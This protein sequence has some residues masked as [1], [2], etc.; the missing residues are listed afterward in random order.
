MSKAFVYLWY[1][2]VNRKYYLGSHKGSPDDNYTHSSTIW[3]SF[4]KNNV[5]KGTKRRILAYGTLEDMRHLETKLLNN[6]KLRRWSQYYNVWISRTPPHP[7]GLQYSKIK[8]NPHLV[9]SK[10]FSKRIKKYAKQPN[11]VLDKLLSVS[12]MLT[13]KYSIKLYIYL[14]NQKKNGSN[15]MKIKELKQ[16]FD[17]PENKYNAIGHLRER[18]LDVTIKQLGEY[19]EYDVSFELIRKGQS[20]GYVRIHWKTKTI[21][22]QDGVN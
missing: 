5:P 11:K 15:F 21:K 9:T 16:I 20:Y 18:V 2:G 17:I 19:A 10:M 7:G 6:R 22:I 13:S 14:L 12:P 1:D 4:T 8:Q 3:E